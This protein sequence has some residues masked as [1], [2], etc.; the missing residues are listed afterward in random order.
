MPYIHEI[1]RAGKTEE[2][3]KYYS[4]YIHPPGMKRQKRSEES[5][6]RIKRSNVRKAEK[7][8]RRL[9][10]ENFRDGDYLVTLDFHN[11]KPRDSAEMQEMITKSIRKLRGALKKEGIEL[12]Y[13][14]TKEIGPRG[15]RHVHMMLTKCDIEIIR[16]CWEYGGIH[17]DPLYSDGQYSKIASYFMKYALKTE[18]TEGELI[19]KRY[20]GSRNLKKPVVEKKIILSRTFREEAPEKKGFILDKDSEIRGITEQGYPYYSYSYIRVDDEGRYLHTHDAEKPK[21]TKWSL[22]IRDRDEGAAVHQREE[23]DHG[24]GTD[25]GCR[26]KRSPADYIVKGIKKIKGFFR[27][28]D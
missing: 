15:S 1:C 28:R 23:P 20:Y 12:K 24:D 8:L 16:K 13:I 19:G 10:N 4:W 14:Y 2:H 27:R 9:M 11:H 18:K 25:Y 7:D 17:V 21:R 6:E 3:C 22:H 5:E 26:S